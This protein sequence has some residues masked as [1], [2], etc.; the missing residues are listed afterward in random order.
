[1]QGLEPQP[2]RAPHLAGRV[3][4]QPRLVQAPPCPA[5]A[6]AR[7]GSANHPRRASVRL[8]SPAPA[9]TQLAHS[10]AAVHRLASIHHHHHLPSRSTPSSVRT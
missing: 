4:C 10:A 9:R 1:M 2:G 5:R 7:L 3:P 8:A 6:A